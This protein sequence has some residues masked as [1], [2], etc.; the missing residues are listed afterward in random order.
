MKSVEFQ[1]VVTELMSRAARISS[2]VVCAVMGEKMLQM[3][4]LEKWNYS[5]RK[6]YYY[7]IVVV[8][9]DDVVVV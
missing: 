1:C 7:F 5:L 6:N 2:F 4:Q 9:V 3:N 8:I